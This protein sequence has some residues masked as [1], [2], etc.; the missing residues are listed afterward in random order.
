MP[1]KPDYLGA[2]AGAGVVGA[3][4]GREKSTFG[5]VEISFSFSTVKLAFFLVAEEHRGDV[6]RE[7]PDTDVV[8]L[9]R[10]ECER[11]RATAMRF[12]VLELR[13]KIAEQRVGFRA[14]DSS[15]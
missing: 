13:D 9:H 3:G 2:G 7:R 12:S 5:A 8:I 14:A 10:P 6:F 15:R 4:D 1:V 11:L